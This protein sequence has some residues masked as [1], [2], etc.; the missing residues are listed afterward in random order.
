MGM[1]L[2][3]P[4][5][6]CCSSAHGA[7]SPEAAPVSSA[8]SRSRF[9]VREGTW[10]TISGHRFYDEELWEPEKY[11]AWQDRIWKDPPSGKVEILPIERVDGPGSAPEDDDR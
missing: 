1:R 2:P 10:E 5:S 9:P 7:T 3:S 11:F 6:R 4:G 8:T